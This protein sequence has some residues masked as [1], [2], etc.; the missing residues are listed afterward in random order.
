[1]ADAGYRIDIG[2]FKCTVF[3]DGTLEHDGE[4]FALNNLYIDSV[5]HKILIDTGCGD[6]F[7]ATAGRLAENLEAAGIKRPDIDR[8]ILTHGHVDHAVGA[9]DSRGKPV[10][11]NARYITSR[12]EWEHWEEGPGDNELQ[13]MFFNGARKHLLPIP[14]RFDLAD[15]NEEV[16]PLIRFIPA[17]GHTPGNVMVDIA[18]DGDRLLCIGDIIHSPLEFEYPEH[19]AAF[20]VAPEQAI[21]TR[22]KILAD[23]AQSGVLVFACHFTFP[24]LGHITKN[25]GVFAWQPI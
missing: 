20:D 3:S 17:Y 18:S 1:M 21:K 15:D 22:T 23:I 14:D 6:G 25:K 12:R 5:E 9:F 11:P 13:N 10:F 16:L 2:R 8:V 19:L 24:G 7:Q 4:L